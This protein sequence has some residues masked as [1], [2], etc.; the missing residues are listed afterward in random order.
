M[1]FY[2]QTAIILNCKESN[3]KEAVKKAEKIPFAQLET[4]D[5]QFKEINNGVN[6]LFNDYC[7]GFESLA[8][9]LSIE[10]KQPVMLLYIDD[11]DYWGYYFYENGNKLDSF[12]PWPDYYEKIS[13]EKRKKLAGQSKIISKYFHIR[14]EEFIKY[15]VTW[16]LVNHRMKAYEEDE[17]KQ[18]DC[19]QMVDFMRKIGYPF[20]F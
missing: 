11:G 10:V 20:A 18:G 1:G 8:K 2:L 17:F 14:E 9:E 16:K 19:W 4:E 15:L 12:S 3:A 5:C 13:E 7:Q 6:I